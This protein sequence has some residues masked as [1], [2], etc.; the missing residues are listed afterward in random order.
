MFK[1]KKPH[2]GHFNLLACM[3]ILIQS[4]KAALFSNEFLI[5]LID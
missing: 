1:A 2:V 4:K 5:F 3:H